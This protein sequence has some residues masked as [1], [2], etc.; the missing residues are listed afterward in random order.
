MSFKEMFP[1]GIDKIT[2]HIRGSAKRV[3]I[4]PNDPAS[5][6]ESIGQIMGRDIVKADYT[7]T[8]NPEFDAWREAVAGRETM[9]SFEAWRAARSR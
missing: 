4:N 5:V 8:E 6:Y 3:I 1:F 9:E 7:P 2:L